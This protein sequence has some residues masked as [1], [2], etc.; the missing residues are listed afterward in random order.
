MRPKNA[1]THKFKHPD[2]CLLPQIQNNLKRILVYDISED[3]FHKEKFFR[4]HDRF[5]I[6]S[7]SSINYWFGM[8]KKYYKTIL[9]HLKSFRFKIYLENLTFCYKFCT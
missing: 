4:Q 5:L 9:I 6:F 3:K 7:L 2:I 8:C 1:T